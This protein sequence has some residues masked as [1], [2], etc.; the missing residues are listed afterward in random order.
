MPSVRGPT[1]SGVTPSGA[2]CGSI[3]VKHRIREGWL[4][5][6]HRAQAS[7]LFDTDD[8]ASEREKRHA[9]GIQKCC[10]L[11]K[12]LNL[13]EKPIGRARKALKLNLCT[14]HEDQF[15]P[16]HWKLSRGKLDA[17]GHDDEVHLEIRERMLKFVEFRNFAFNNH[18][19]DEFQMEEPLSGETKKPRT[20]AS[21]ESDANL[22]PQP[23]APERR[24]YNTFLLLAFFHA[25]SHPLLYL[26]LLY[27][28][29]LCVR[30]VRAWFHTQR[31]S[32][33]Q[34]E[35]HDQARA[36]SRGPEDQPEQ[37]PAAE[38]NDEEK[39]E[40]QEEEV[41]EE[42][43]S[44]EDEDEEDQSTDHDDD[45]PQQPPSTSQNDTGTQ[46]VPGPAEWRKALLD[47]GIALDRFLD[48]RWSEDNPAS[49]DK[50]PW[51]VFRTK[52]QL[53]Y[54]FLPTRLSEREVTVFIKAMSLY[55]NSLLKKCRTI[56]QPDRFSGRRVF[57]SIGDAEE[58]TMV[59]GKVTM[60]SQCINAVWAQYRTDFNRRRPSGS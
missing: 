26:Y 53:R 54:T 19:K 33:S 25:F 60:V 59:Q 44:S 42:D 52:T 46:S 4:C 7:W 14:Y 6:D 1:C 38:E 28:F 15:P 9:A 29:V 34:A 8:R 57:L 18:P 47:Y 37:E 23:A 24:Y 49:F 58:R 35:T 5:K 11:T 50:I 13:C 43:T 10:G 55:D 27:L 12:A 3:D 40:T 39:E 41:P 45:E 51:P 48:S 31:R 32:A 2:R 22:K 56:W 16:S 20:Q 17:G 36:E 21:P 30:R